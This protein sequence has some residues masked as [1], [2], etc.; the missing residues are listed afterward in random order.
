[1]SRFSV[2]SES[3]GHKEE[4]LEYRRR[5]ENLRSALESSGWDG[6]W[7]RRASYDDGGTLGSSEDQEWRIDSIAQ[8][9]A[10]LSGAADPVRA[11]Q[12]MREVRQRLVKPEDGL[13][14]LATPPFDRTPL[15]PGYI[16]GYPPGVRE[17]G[18]SYQ[19]AAIW[20]AFAFLKVGFAED[21]YALFRMINPV[22]RADTPEGME[23]YQVEP[24]IVAAD[25]SSQENHKGQGGWTWYTG[26]AGW[27]FRL[28]LEGILGF[29]RTGN[30]LRMDPWIPKDWPGF[31]IRYRYGRTCYHI[32]VQNPDGVSRG[33]GKVLLDGKEI[34]DDRIPL[35]DD[36]VTHQVQVWM[37]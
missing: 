15:D 20:T 37:G 2:L 14:L 12:A 21:A 22:N 31:R 19:H 10:V 5:A 34:P 1:L 8:S 32:D 18:G 23:R 29:Q 3:I 25:V 30:A 26:S 28:G 7:Y 9:W 17:N 35:K 4:A 6:R 33:S 27:L 11:E 24:Y 13:V 16:K 36:G